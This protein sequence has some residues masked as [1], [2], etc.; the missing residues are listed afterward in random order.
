[1]RKMSN[2]TSDVMSPLITQK[3]NRKKMSGNLK[4]IKQ[5]SIVA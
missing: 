5:I 3:G 1:M 2:I 4:T